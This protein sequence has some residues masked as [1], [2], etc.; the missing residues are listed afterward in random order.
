M[1]LPYCKFYPRDWLGDASLRS[2]SY[3]ARGLWA[4]MLCLMAAN[5][6]R[7]GYLEVGGRALVDAAEVARMT[8]GEPSEA[9]KLL[10]ELERA[11]VFSRD[12]SGCIFCRRI[13]KDE[14]I[15][16]ARSEAGAQGGNPN[17][18]RVCL[19]KRTSEELKQTLKQSVVSGTGT[20]TDDQRGLKG[21]A[22]EHMLEIYEAYPRHVAKQP[23]LKAI[24]KAL[25]KMP[26]E[27]LLA[28]TRDYN[29][30]C[31][32]TKKDPQYI[33]HPA[34]WFGQERFLEP[35]E[36]SAA[37][38]K[39]RHDTHPCNPDSIYHKPN[40]TPEQMA[41]FTALKAQLAKVNSQ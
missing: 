40:T 26:F 27:P 22:H 36:L 20:G 11:G 7:R 18:R 33:P 6:G 41:E 28:K 5:D 25:Q 30:H 16:Q 19:T 35:L 10:D 21:E 12:G 14:H 31:K 15:R 32:A 37:S 17:L 3:A 9:K 4:D 34:T 23:A 2:C 39:Q 24:A 8:C 29:Q 38:M 13:V 1:N